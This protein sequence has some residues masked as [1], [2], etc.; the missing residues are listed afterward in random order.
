MATDAPSHARHCIEVLKHGKHVA[1]AV[2][3]VFGSLEDAHKLFEAVKSTG[4]KY[5]MFE[6]S[7][8]HE[9]LYAMRQI[10]NAGGLRQARVFRRR[11]L[12]LHAHADR[13]VQGLARRPAAAMVSD[14]LECLLRR[15]DR[16]QLHRGFLPG[17]AEHDRPLAAG[18]QPLQES[19]RHRNRPVPHQRRR[20][21]AHG[22]QLGYARLRRRD[23]PHSRAEGLLLRQV[24]RAGKEPA[25]HQTS[26]AAAGG[27]QPAATAARTAT[28]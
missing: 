25:R 21:V 6:T 5:M 7:C 26:A 10:Y 11:V 22:R 1:S 23:G 17:H 3:A 16:R 20:H 27:G 12:P 8:F 13:F 4:L 14:A 15:R 2:P 28:S 9:D 19:L 18:E 24:R